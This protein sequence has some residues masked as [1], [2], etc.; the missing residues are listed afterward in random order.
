MSFADQE[1]IAERRKNRGKKR[2]TNIVWNTLTTLVIL[3]SLTAVGYFVL[4]FSNPASSLNPFPPPT[5]PAPIQ[6]PTATMTPILPTATITPLPT[7]TET[8]LAVGGETVVPTNGTPVAQLSSTATTYSPIYLF[9]VKGS[10]VGMSNTTFHPSLDCNWQGVAGKVT[11]IQGKPVDNLYIRLTGTYNGQPVDKATL[12]GGAKYNIGDG[13][14][15]IVL[16]IGSSPVASTGQLTIQLMDASTEVPLSAPIT[17]DTYS[18]CDKNLI[19]I[20]FQQ[21]Q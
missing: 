20:N 6:I 12:S 8:P 21:A 9:A 18:E 1:E 4:L 17:F 7:A 2:R 15:E 16:E 5:M 11:D 10:P 14:Y 13:G 19:L 3:A